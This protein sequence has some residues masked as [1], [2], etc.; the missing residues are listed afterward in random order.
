MDKALTKRGKI[1]APRLATMPAFSVRYCSLHIQG[2]HRMLS[3]LFGGKSF[4][5]YII[6]RIKNYPEFSSD[7]F[8]IH[9]IC[10]TNNLITSIT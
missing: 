4:Y 6:K 5:T 9:E 1:N 10:H 2:G 8:A 7:H 3:A